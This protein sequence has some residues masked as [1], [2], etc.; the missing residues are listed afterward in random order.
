MPTPTKN[1]TVTVVDSEANPVEG[2]RVAMTLNRAEV[3]LAAIV[4]TTVSGVTNG[5]GVVVLAVFPNELGAANSH[6]DVTVRVTGSKAVATYRAWVPNAH[7]NLEDIITI[8]A[9]PGKTDGQISVEAAA[10]SAAAA[11]ISAASAL[12]ATNRALVFVFNGGYSVI[13]VDQV[14]YLP[15][16]FNCT[17]TAWDLLGD[18]VGDIVIDVWKATGPTIPTAPDTIA[19][20]ELPT[21]SAAQGASDSVLS[22]WSVTLVA[23]D[24]L[25][26][27]IVSA[28]TIKR[29]TLVLTADSTP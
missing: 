6:Y 29:A 17:I 19:G 10:A 28:A 25:A 15:V 4:P 11:A 3:Y 23:G 7:C 26:A 9:F 12:S 2:A 24:I 13:P 16:T 8:P 27:R 21:L 14:I 18:V 20:T 1:V 22:T 5:S